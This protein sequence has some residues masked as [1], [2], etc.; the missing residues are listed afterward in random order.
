MAINGVKKKKATASGFSLCLAYVYVLAY[1]CCKMWKQQKCGAS[2]FAWVTFLSSRC[3]ESCGRWQ[4]D[5]SSLRTVSQSNIFPTSSKSWSSVTFLIR[6]QLGRGNCPTH[7]QE[8]CTLCC[9]GQF[10]NLF[11]IQFAAPGWVILT[12]ITNTH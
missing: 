9:A 1:S 2:L 5:T 8:Q 4:F 3:G 7:W 12:V 6:V 11:A 10:V